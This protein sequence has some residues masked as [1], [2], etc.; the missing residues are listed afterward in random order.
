MKPF[1]QQR[2]FFPDP[3]HTLHDGLVMVGGELSVENLVEAYSFGIFPWPQEGYPI[4]WFS[5]PRRGVLELKKVHWPKSFQ[6]FLRKTHWQ[7][8]VNQDFAG[9]LKACQGQSRPGQ[10][11]TWI[12]P[13]MERAYL[14]FH[15]AGYVHSIECREGG[16]LIGGLY[17]V[18]VA[19]VFAGES[20]FYLKPNASKFALWWLTEKL[21]EQGRSFMDIQMVTELP[22]SLGARYIPRDHFL[23]WLEDAKKNPVS[24][25][26]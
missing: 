18:D 5:P 9:V 14:R 3:S 4:L 26:I 10:A 24:L 23:K 20:M 21:R 6:K 19:G 11:G 7:I 8:T 15:Q 25:R 1:A 2:C 13:E 17:G 22:R 12:T 16:Q